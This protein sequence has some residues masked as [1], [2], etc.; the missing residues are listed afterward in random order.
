M[1]IMI[2]PLRHELVALLVRLSRK[3]RVL[4]ER[5]GARPIAATGTSVRPLTGTG[6]VILVGSK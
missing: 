2:A 1:M 6:S 5:E 4:F 3:Y